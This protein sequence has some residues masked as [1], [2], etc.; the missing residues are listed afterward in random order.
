MKKGF[1]LVEIMIVVL[2][3]GIIVA[4][5]VPSF[6]NARNQS[7]AKACQEQ[8]NKLWGAIQQWAM[9][10]GAAATVTPGYTDLIGGTN[11]LTRT[12]QCPVGP[13]NI[14]IVAVD[15]TPVCPN[16]ISEHVAFG[17]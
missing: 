5:A 15:A 12:P 6:I 8:Q 1:T 7:R 17:N 2:I 13:S 16:T 14:A 11:Y 4:I 9:E 3:I 10:K